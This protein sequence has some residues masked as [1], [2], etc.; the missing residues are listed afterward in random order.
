M[1]WQFFLCVQVLL[2]NTSRPAKF[3][4]SSMRGTDTCQ[5]KKI[6]AS[7]VGKNEIHLRAKSMKQKLLGSLSNCSNFFF[8]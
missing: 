2:S 1:E 6:W 4:S 8:F 7:V 3:L 5:I